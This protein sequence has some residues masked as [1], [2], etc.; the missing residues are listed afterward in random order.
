MAL[1]FMAAM[2]GEK[3]LVLLDLF[4]SRDV[5]TPGNPGGGRKTTGQ[6]VRQNWV[7]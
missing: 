3:P 7:E 4:Q 5:E 6:G 1:P 2:V